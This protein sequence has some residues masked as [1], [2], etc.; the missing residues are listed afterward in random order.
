MNYIETNDTMIMK[1]GDTKNFSLTLF[2]DNQILRNA[3]E[4][5]IYLANS[6][7]VVLMKE[8]T[9]ENGIIEFTVHEEDNV[10][11]GI[12]DIEVHVESIDQTFPEKDY[13]QLIVKPSLYSRQ[14]E[15]I[16]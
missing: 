1:E 3:N 4:A 9:I 10:P 13:L 8:V 11:F 7:N 15:V 6:D 5:I 12:Y 2:K 16:E 14:K